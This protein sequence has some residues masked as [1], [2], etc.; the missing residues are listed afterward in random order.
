MTKY[1]QNSYQI[2]TSDGT[3]D[4]TASSLLQTDAILSAVYDM[5]E[6]ILGFTL[7][8]SQKSL[9]LR[10]GTD[11][12]L[13]SRDVLVLLIEVENYFCIEISQDEE[14]EVNTIHDLLNLIQGKL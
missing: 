13:D 1:F 2:L 8:P 9:S 14:L 11:Y 5:L 4:V 10:L 3:I 6:N 7:K 12:E